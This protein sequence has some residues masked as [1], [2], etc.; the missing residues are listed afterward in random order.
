MHP[1]AQLEESLC[2]LEAWL[3]E[4]DFKG[5]DPFDALRSPI[6]RILCF[7]NR[8][9]G[10]AWVQLFR[11]LPINLR[12]LLGITPAHN[13]KGMGLF[14]ASYIRR[15]CVTKS[16]EHR[17]R[18][19]FFGDWLLANRCKSVP[20]AC[21]GYNFDWPNRA[22]FAPAGTPNIVSTV[23]IG[24]ALLDR[25][26]LLG[27]EEDLKAVRSA[28]DFMLNRLSSLTDATGEC[29]A[30]TPLD[31][32]YVHNANLLGASLLARVANLTGEESLRARARCAASF[33]VSRQRP[34]GSWPYGIS[35]ADAFVDNFHTGYNLETLMDYAFYAQDHSFDESIR[36]G[37]QYWKEECF[38]GEGLPKY[39]ADRLYPI[40]IHAVSQTILTFLKFAEHDP[41]AAD[42]ACRMAEWAIANMQEKSGYFDFRIGRY[43]KN[44]IAY[45]R[46][47]QGWMF[48]A[49]AEM[50]LFGTKFMPPE[51]SS[52]RSGANMHGEFLGTPVDNVNMQEVFDRVNEFICSAK[53]HYIVVNNAN[54]FRLMRHDP[55][56]KEIAYKADLILTERALAVCCGILGNPLKEDV[57]GVA[58]AQELL[59]H[60]DKHGHSIYF[61]GGTAE[62]QSVLI[63]KVR[64]EFPTLKI[65]GFHH[66]YFLGDKD[67]FVVEDILA[68]KPEVLVVALGS[69]I[70]EYWIHKNLERLNVPI[71]VG[72]GGSLDVIA[73]LKKDTPRWIRKAGVEWLFRMMQ[74]PRRY[75]KRYAQIVPYLMFAVFWEGFLGF[76]RDWAYSK[77]RA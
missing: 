8:L 72:V 47:S 19:D 38:T 65:A 42:R 30:Y 70:Q 31:K 22:F 45:I 34:D 29:F 10:I 26:D 67:E 48:R 57:A 52:G 49:L 75:W 50:E 12:G 32:R 55:L 63:D 46:W 20:E 18:I 11:R 40:D 1:S 39:F 14:L 3:I 66:G 5:V 44:R 15:Y 27:L 21:W 16:A 25:Y 54:K 61:L 4:K 73:G 36:R 51:G 41:E 62:V 43:F 13:A 69:P 33:S 7:R 60:C 59:P 28:C 68:K 58:F 17:A 76:S 23:F 64:R 77:K 56:L 6:V 37:Y 74:D 71:S 9:L 2:R 35:D 24:H 53:P